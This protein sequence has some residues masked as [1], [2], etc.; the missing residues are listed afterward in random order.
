MKNRVQLIGNLG[1]NPEVKNM[2]GGKKMARFRIATNEVK[3]NHTNTEW[4]TIVVW[5][6]LA[7]MAEQS[8]QKGRGVVVEGKIKYSEYTDGKGVKRW[9]TEIVAHNVFLLDKKQEKPAEQ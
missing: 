3:A 6:K 5:E 8:L 9:S 7:D 2:E 4:H 1:A